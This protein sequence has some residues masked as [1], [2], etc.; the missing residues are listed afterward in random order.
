MKNNGKR[1]SSKRILEVLGA[2]VKEP[3]AAT[4]MHLSHTLDIP[5]ATIYRQLEALTE[6]GFIATSPSGTFVPGSRLRSLMLNS[7]TYEPQ[8]TLR[9]SALNEL[10]D[11]LDETVSLSVPIG[12]TLVYYDRFESHWPIQKTNVHVGDR[13]PLIYSASGKLYLSTFERKAAIEVFKGLQPSGRSKNSIT[14]QKHFSEELDLI[15]ARGYSFDNEEW[16]DGMIGASVPIY[17]QKGDLCSCLSTHSLT[18]RKTLDELK[19]KIPIMQIAAKKFEQT[20]FL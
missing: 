9:R 13:L 7:L 18:T 15:Q 19:A 12:E 1:T 14:T 6:E 5:L 3:N 11:A 2:V 16:I 8:V 10:S 17:N 20:L 4:A